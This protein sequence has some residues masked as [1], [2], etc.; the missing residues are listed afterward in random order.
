MMKFKVVHVRFLLLRTIVAYLA[1]SGRNVAAEDFGN[2][3]AHGAVDCVHDVAPRFGKRICDCGYRNEDF[4]VPRFDGSTTEIELVNC[5]SLLIKSDT[6]LGLFGLSRLSIINVENLILEPGALNFARND[7]AARLKISFINNLIEELP[8]NL[9]SGPIH[10]IALVRCRIGVFRPFSVANIGDRLETL[11]M[12]ETFINRIER[13]AFK[14]FNV[15]NILLEG[16]KFVAPISSQSFYEVDVQE[17]FDIRN[18]SFYQLMPS[19]FT[20]K[21]VTHLQIQN[22]EFEKIDGE[23][24]NLQIRKSVRI[25]G[26]YFNKI[27][28][29]AFIAISL[30][31]SYFSRN[32][33]KPALQFSNNRIG[34]LDQ[35]NALRFSDDFNLQL[36]GVHIA[37]GISCNDVVS[38]EQSSLFKS[39]PNDIFFS[40]S[41]AGNE[42]KSFNDIRRVQCLENNFWLYLIIGVTVGAIVLVLICSI[43]S[44]YCLAQRRKKLRA[45]EVV[46]PEPR[47]Y[48]ETQIVMQIEN[49]GL[50]KTDL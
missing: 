19:A 24:L 26:N 32:S 49:H 46:M 34:Q 5:K 29:A 13:H 9:I 47:T 30:D 40:T 10:E 36:E 8:S 28:D 6:F 15:N 25:T 11:R 3:D 18:C 23:S 1:L 35:S 39:H 22:S 31:S 21:N 33:Q 17:R 7:P 4:I 12:G 2:L 42:F 38:L 45:L 43:V 37:H 27:N 16:S 41:G 48:R 50:L 14:R 44:W 20:M